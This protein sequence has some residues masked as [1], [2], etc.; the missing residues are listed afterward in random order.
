M[1]LLDNTEVLNNYFIAE[2]NDK[3]ALIDADT[4]A[5]NACLE[6]E[7]LYYNTETG[8][9]EWLINLDDAYA[10]AEGRIDLIVEQT[11]C[12]HAELYFSASSKQ[13]FRYLQVSSMYKDN[14]KNT[15]YPAGLLDLKLMLNEY[16]DGEIARN[17]EADD[18]VVALYNP[19]KHILCAIDKDVLNAVPGKHWNYYQRAAYSRIIKGVEKLYD[20]IPA[21]YFEVDEAHAK[22]WP[23]YQCII[24]DTA[25]GIKGVPGLGHAKAG[26]FVSI[27]NTEL[28]NWNGLVKAFESKGL[29]KIDALI[30]MRLVNMHQYDPITKEVNLWMPPEELV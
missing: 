23:Y 10:H 22:Y 9:D 6:C 28:E 13:T 7:Y 19:D 8:E 15:R 4:I 16:Y 30:T 26:N 27:D 18:L 11:G 14:R 3:I 1:S 24:G 17:V 12:T 2:P 5:F 25:D 20:E 21:Q 29:G